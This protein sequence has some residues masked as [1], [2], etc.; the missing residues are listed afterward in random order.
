MR[1]IQFEKSYTIVGDNGEQFSAF[2]KADDNIIAAE[3]IAEGNEP[4]IYTE[5]VTSYAELRQQ[6]YKAESDP[7]KTAIENEAMY[8]GTEPDYTVWTAKVSEIKL[9]YPKP[10]AE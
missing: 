3:W 8:D 1:V 5:P 9:R 6:A 7:I 4:E 10:E 2:G